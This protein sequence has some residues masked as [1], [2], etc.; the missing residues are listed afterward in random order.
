MMLSDW[1][2]REEILAV[3]HRWWLAVLAFLLGSLIGI[4]ISFL[5]PANYRAESVLGVAYNGDAIY[6]NPDDYKNWQ[7][8][9]LNN[10]ALAPDVLRETLKRLR[11]IDP[12]WG[13]ISRRQ[14]HAM[15]D[16]SWRNTGAW[17]FFV[18]NRSSQ[19]AVDGVEAWVQVFLDKYQDALTSAGE[20]FSD[21]ARVNELSQTEAEKTTRLNQL[22]VAQSALQLWQDGVAKGQTQQ[23]LD[24]IARWRLYSL[25]ANAAGFDPAWSFI[26]DR[27]P[28]TGATLDAYLQWSQELQGL[29]AQEIQNLQG[30]LALLKQDRKAATLEYE[31]QVQRSRGLTTTTVV[32]KASED[33]STVRAIRNM[34]TY[35][36]VGGLIGVL[37]WLFIW[38]LRR[39]PGF[40]H[41]NP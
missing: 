19:R 33:A 39:R 35:A 29:L 41:D 15:L 11:L 21:S 3:S 6:R 40:R 2:L 12:Y 7:L 30:E 20:L 8:Q 31:R 25:A 17:R 9:Q 24:T 34:P 16:L 27:L 23:P 32:N 13:D 14:F 10:L 22:L 28:Q 5:V 18:N 36:L 26:L 38:L 4:G 37:T 1:N